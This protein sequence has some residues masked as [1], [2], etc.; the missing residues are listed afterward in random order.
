MKLI[1]MLLVIIIAMV[2]FF[3]FR[4]HAYVTNTD[5]PYDEVGIALNSN[6]PLPIRKWG[7]G[8][9]RATFA[10][11]MPPL[12]CQVEGGDGRSWL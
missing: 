3:G 11:V 6:L 7:C 10:N 2:G 9:L 4:W 5:S 8:K 1:R 12:G